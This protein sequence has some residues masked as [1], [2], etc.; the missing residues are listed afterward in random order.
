MTHA[1]AAADPIAT[2]GSIVVAQKSGDL[3]S[4]TD[5]VTWTL[6]QAGAN[7]VAGKWCAAISLFVFASGAVIWTSADGISWSSDAVTFASS[8]IRYIVPGD[9]SVVAI[10]SN[11]GS[12]APQI[13][14]TTDGVTWT[15]RTTNFTGA[16]AIAGQG[17]FGNARFIV[18]G[19]ANGSTGHQEAV[20]STDDGV[21]WAQITIP[22][23]A[24]GS[25]SR[26]NCDAFWANDLWIV[27]RNSG[28]IAVSVDAATWALYPSGFSTDGA[29]CNI[30]EFHFHEGSWYAFPQIVTAAASTPTIYTY[31]DDGVTW[32]PKPLGYPAATTV[33]VNSVIS[34]DDLI[35]LNGSHGVYVSEGVTEYASAADL[36][37]DSLAPSANTYKTFKDAGGS[38]FRLG[39]A[40]AGQVTCNAAEGATAADRTTA[41]IWKRILEDRA[42]KVS[43]TDFSAGDITT[44]DSAA[45]GEC[46]EHYP[47]PV[48]ISTVLDRVAASAGAWWLPDR[49]GLYRL[50]QLVA[51]S[52]TAAAT[53][54]SANLK[55]KLT[56]RPS[57][58]PGFGVPCW[59][60]VLYYSRNHTV[61]TSG[62][63]GKVTDVARADL[64]QEWRVVTAEDASV[65]TK[66]P[67]APVLTF[68]TLLSDAADAQDECDR[69]LA[70][71]KV[72]RDRYPNAVQA[73]AA[74]SLLDVGDVVSLEHERFGLSAGKKFTLV[75]VTPNAMNREIGL[76]LW[77]GT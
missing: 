41:Q 30:G 21:T 66:H 67:L 16:I 77:G 71:R 18:T 52:G 76:E 26:I 70:L 19:M 55:Q 15:S 9:N 31:S 58:D 32:I 48:T 23:D 65:L 50:K 54:R 2:D 33:Q 47:E 5:L 49:T 57:T 68:V 34:F 64:A 44:L 43:G 24:G 13:W 29:A 59:K 4:S 60:V 6:R 14:S 17:G 27:E 75:A 36:E 35:V 37:D 7:A 53:F 8:A 22:Y 12:T 38:Y 25:F 62:L 42:G 20:T 73:T 46:G 1:F 74:N 56:R 45:A 72:Q 69:Q 51:P 3:Y 63:A 61:Q 40:P 10:G 39:A 11:A 28:L